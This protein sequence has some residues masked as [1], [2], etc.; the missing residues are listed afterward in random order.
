MA[1]KDIKDPHYLTVALE[2]IVNSKDKIKT[3]NDFLDESD[4]PYFDN[5]ARNIMEHEEK[6][7]EIARR[8]YDDNLEGYI[9]FLQTLRNEM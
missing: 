4:I 9:E 5:F 6:K 7:K 3:L 2:E 1:Y 8:G